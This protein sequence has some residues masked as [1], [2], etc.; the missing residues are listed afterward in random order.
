MVRDL[1]V[2]MKERD[3]TMTDKSIA[4]TPVFDVTWGNI[5]EED[6][7]QDALICNIIIPEAYW[8]LMKYDDNGEIHLHFFSKYKPEAKNFRIRVVALK[9]GKYS[10]FESIKGDFGVPACSY[11]LSRN[12]ASPI[13]ACALPF[14]DTDGEFM[15]KLVRSVREEIVGRAYVY[16]AKQTDIAIDFSDNQASQLLTLCAPGQNYHYPTTG[17][18]ITRYLNGVIAHSDLGAVLQEQFEADNKPLKSATYDGLTCNIEIVATPE[19]DTSALETTS[20]PNLGINF[21]AKFTDEYVRRNIV[22]NTLSDI[23]F[24]SVLNEYDSVLNLIIFEDYSTSCTRIANN[25][26]EGK[27]DSDG[28]VI[29]SD[30]SYIVSATLEPNSII[31]F[32]D[33][34]E[35][36]M[37]DNPVFIIN[38]NDE[39]RLYTALIEQPYWIEEDC[40][41]CMI[42]KRRAEIKYVISKSQFESGRGLFLV[43]QSSANIKNMVGLVQD[44][45]T[46]RV[47]GI[48]SNNTNISDIILDEITQHIYATQIII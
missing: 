45:N 35:D 5:F 10:L 24:I 8:G 25:V 36:K 33:E 18:N 31:L 47:L 38:D 13:M 23:D 43:P 29:E 15:V 11:A 19:E 40:H 32:D 7:A 39:T 12:I 2:D 41:R 37:S 4:N 48:V 9:N 34:E 1:V 22:I 30:D 3:L 6:E 44:I 28:N 46:G 27:F 42:L 20:I 21:F 17:A 16:S 14:I 26:I